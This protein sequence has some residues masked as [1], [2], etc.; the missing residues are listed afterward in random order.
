MSEHKIV[1]LLVVHSLARLNS[2]IVDALARNRDSE[3]TLHM[4]ARHLRWSYASAQHLETFRGF[5]RSIPWSHS[6]IYG[7]EID[8]AIAFLTGNGHG[9]IAVLDDILDAAIREARRTRGTTLLC[10]GGPWDGNHVHL[11]SGVDNVMAMPPPTEEEIGAAD[12]S[13]LAA[14][15]APNIYSRVNFDFHGAD[16]GGLQ[17]LALQGASRRS[18]IAMLVEGYNPKKK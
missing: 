4:V 14:M 5:D 8:R 16:A 17:V 15:A 3:T 10:V 7:R 11:A 6:G 1:G 13:A 9:P 12:V 18:V 2:D